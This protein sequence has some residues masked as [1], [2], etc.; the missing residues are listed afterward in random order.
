MVGVSVM[1]KGLCIGALFLFL[2]L[3]VCFLFAF[4]TPPKSSCVKLEKE[5]R[6]S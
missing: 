5:E 4:S 3:F 6:K 2:F 1:N